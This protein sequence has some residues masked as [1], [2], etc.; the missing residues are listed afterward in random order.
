MPIRDA[1]ERRPCTGVD[2]DSRRSDGGYRLRNGLQ[3]L[4][5]DIFQIGAVVPSGNPRT[6]ERKS[7]CGVGGLHGSLRP[8]ILRPRRKNDPNHG[9][10][11]DREGDYSARSFHVGLLKRLVRRE[12]HAQRGDLQRFQ[13]LPQY[14]PPQKK[15]SEQNTENRQL[16]RTDK[17]FDARLQ[18]MRHGIGSPFAC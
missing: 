4:S 1:V 2:F 9:K 6:I 8:H 12:R 7:I 15:V 14:V 17:R 16:A 18:E 13:Q 11:A 10:K 5:I 3:F